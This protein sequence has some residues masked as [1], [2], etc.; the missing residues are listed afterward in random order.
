MTV[1]LEIL[2]QYGKVNLIGANVREKKNGTENW[3]K[4]I[5]SLIEQLIDE[6]WSDEQVEKTYD[7]YMTRLWGNNERAVYGE[8]GFES[9]WKRREAEML[10]DEIRTVAVLGYN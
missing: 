9:A 2:Y 1:R 10:N 5:V 3:Y 4:D 6:S 8:T 7:S